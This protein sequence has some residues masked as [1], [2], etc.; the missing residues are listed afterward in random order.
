[1]A[2]EATE[3]TERFSLLPSTRQPLPQPDNAQMEKDLRLSVLG[4]LCGRNL[5]TRGRP[6]FDPAFE[7]DQPD[8]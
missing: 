4:D 2:T 7:N 5:L 8:P 3:G 1:L 6:N